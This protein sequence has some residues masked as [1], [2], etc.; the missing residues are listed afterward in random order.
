M[1]RALTLRS[2]MFLSIS[3]LITLALIGLLLG[4][5]SVM[6]M[7]REQERLI[8]HNFATI[9]SSQQLR[10]S[11]D[12]Q[13]AQLLSDSPDAQ[14]LV[15]LRGQFD[16]Y[17]AEG[18]AN[19]ANGVERT[20]YERID[21]ANQEFQGQVSSSGSSRWSLV[22]ESDFSRSFTALHQYLLAL[23]S[24]AI[25]TISDAE[26]SSRLHAWLIASLLGLVGVAILVIGFVT[27]H[28]IAR[29]FGAP[30]EAL[31]Q[32][33]DRIGKGDFEVSLPVSR[34]AEMAS[35]SRRFGLM[36]QALAEYKATNIEAV[37]AGQK[38]LQAVLDSIDDG[39]VILDRRSRI[40]HANP[41]AS[42]QLFSRSDPHGQLLGE[43]IDN[44][45]LLQATGLVLQ[46]ESMGDTPRDLQ[47]EISGENRLLAWTLAPVAH[48]DGRNMGAVLV[49]RDVTE[50]RAFERVRSEFVLRASHE[51]R[52]PVT[53]LHMAFALLRE[54]LALA[55]GSRERELADTVDEEMQR[56][57]RLIDDL[58]NFSRYQDGQ[59]KLDRRP[60]AV[61]ELLEQARQRFLARAQAHDIGLGIVMEDELPVLD[62]DR[63]RLE[64]VLDNLIGNALRHTPRGGSVQLLAQ[65]QGQRVMLAVED[66]GEGIA[67]SQQ[68]R[69][70]EPFV[71]VGRRAG[72]AGLGLALCKEIV[73]LHGGRIGVRSQPGQGTRIYML[74]PV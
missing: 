12:D 58:L 65:R 9:A 67:Y 22:V 1:K 74:L 72:G 59:Q 55:E 29:R 69:I 10:Q 64:R 44:Q 3:A 28:G 27:A 31:A 5:F 42:R 34:E 38:R 53:G 30:I 11:L 73:Q 71:Q 25:Q 52:T 32:A 16:R 23:H 8:S 15:L 20:L 48:D 35:L 21:Q 50:L 49:L 40:E 63:L 56:L 51:L 68:A 46:G 45:E 66:S 61:G 4:V 47:V 6:L 57:V 2:R 13:L 19:A 39:L 54:R 17:L 36:A 18:R 24:H 41:V 70:F 14:R 62:V 33:A 43:L 37:L 60:C 26:R 7:G